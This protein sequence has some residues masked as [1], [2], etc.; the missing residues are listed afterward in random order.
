MLLAN[1]IHWILKMAQHCILSESLA[2]FA[3]C[4]VTAKPVSGDKKKYYSDCTNEVFFLGE[5]PQAKVRLPREELVKVFGIVEHVLGANRVKIRSVDGK[6]HGKDSGQNEKASL[7]ADRRCPCYSTL[8]FSR[9][10]SGHLMEVPRYA[11]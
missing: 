1:F 6:T 5:E 9:Q 3:T 7:A 4:C 11:S 2:L 8:G 10:Q